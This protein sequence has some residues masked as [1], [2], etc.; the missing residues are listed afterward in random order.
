MYYNIKSKT[1]KLIYFSILNNKIFYYSLGLLFKSD[2]LLKKN[3]RR[4]INSLRLLVSYVLKINSNF[5]QKSDNIF[6]FNSFVNRKLLNNIIGLGLTSK[7]NI[8]GL[9]LFKHNSFYFKIKRSIKRR[10]TKR[11]IS[12]S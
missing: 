4:S 8:T 10:I 3:I 11:L 1:K 7:T 6:L 5:L 2:V 12:Y 9:I